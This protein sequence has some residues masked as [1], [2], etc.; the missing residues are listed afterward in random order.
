MT[1]KKRLKGILLAGSIFGA[2]F[3]VLESMV[4]AL[5]FHEG[6][7][8]GQLMNRDPHEIW[9]RLFVVYVILLMTSLLIEV[10]EKRRKDAESLEESNKKF[11]AISNTATDAIILMDNRGMISYWNP[12][13]ERMFGYTS[14]EAVGRELHT[15]LSP[16]TYHKDYRKGFQHF[17][18]SGRGPVVGKTGEFTAL[19][20]DGST[21]P[22]EVS[23]SSIK[24]GNAW[25][26]AGFIRDITERKRHEKALLQ[27]SKEWRATFDATRDIIL[28][29]DRKHRTVKANRAA[30]RFLKLAYSEIIGRKCYQLFCHDDKSMES[31][32]MERMFRSGQHEEKEIY[33][34]ERSMWI[35]IAVDP[36]LDEQ[37]EIIGSVHVVRDITE[38]KE[39]QET[40]L[41]HN[42]E[43][44]ETFNI[45]NDAI[46]IHDNDHNIILAN[47]A[48]EEMLGLSYMEILGRKCF[49][50]YHGT[51]TPPEMC[52]SCRTLKSGVSS[53]TEVFEPHLGKHIEIKALPRFDAEN[54]VIGLVH[55]VRD[56][57]ARKNAEEK[58]RHLQEQL[59]Q[60][61][62]MESIGRLAGGVAH[63]F[64]NILSAILGYTELA[65]DALPEDHPVR[66]DL[67]IIAEAGNKAARLTRQLL[68][69]SR[70]QV[71]EIKPVNLN[72]IVEEMGKMLRRMIG[73]DISLTLHTASPVRNVLAD[74]SQIEQILMNLAINA[75]DAM[76]QGGHL[77]IE[78]SDV[79][80]S[81]E[82]ARNHDGIMPGPHVMLAVT[83]TG[84]GMSKEVQEKIFEPFYT[85]KEV[86]KGTG[87][88]LATVY[89]IVKQ[90]GGTIRVHS[91]PG[92]GTTFKIYLPT[93]STEIP[94]AEE[95]QYPPLQGGK[96]T[97]LVV[98]D[99]P[100]ILKL[101][102]TTLD[103][104]GYQVLSAASGVE[105][106]DISRSH[107]GTIDLLLSDVVM[108]GINGVLLSETLRTERPTIRVIFMSGY[109]D[110]YI[111]Q[112][113]LL[114]LGAA[115]L[116]K[117]VTPHNIAAKL[118][119]VLDKQEESPQTTMHPA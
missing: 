43:W 66:E 19:R 40:I 74:A 10:R 23:T 115:F 9:E 62:K 49:Q 103:Q 59:Q 95:E 105:A 27:A 55:V 57:T 78:T 20:K 54:R 5:F 113:G 11:Q 22:I 75:R 118:R 108:P 119:E 7:F 41:K 89:G 98:E 52:P 117:P 47:R 32:P 46:T 61:Q 12:A 90:H 88:G 58:Q 97:I 8:V 114:D 68:A 79:I 101:I 80:L 85:T 64:N 3:W 76:P 56:V 77:V 104:L 16:T 39:M 63:D 73:E 106:L 42:R 96:E 110:S 72:R 84:E 69:F 71:L 100:A 37:K 18:K 45:I 30:A 14:S 25:H 93:D 2:L 109:T 111:A 17:R 29:L 67:K 86:G 21:F 6:S 38:V 94:A 83:D 4:E 116:Q 91:K 13:A 81:E 26:A 92:K 107:D 44:E 50:S 60:S 33:L 70:K 99:E 24:I 36:I 53:V 82:Y 34:P 1:V 51:G 87:L 35:H 102:V 28:M 65:R 112:H 48:A 31:C 15:F